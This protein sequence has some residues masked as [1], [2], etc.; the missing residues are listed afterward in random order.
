M[1]EIPLGLRQALEAGECVLFIGAG[2]GGHL[3]RGDE[4]A[5]S[6]AKL[7]EEM[8]K[9]FTLAAG[10]SI[11]LSKVAQI[12]EIRKGRKEL[13]A[14]VTKRLSGFRPDEVFCWIS[15]VRWKAIFTTNYDDALHAA[16]ANTPACPQNPVFSDSASNLAAFDPRFQVP[17]YYLHGR[18]WGHDG[19]PQLIITE[20]DYAQ[21]RKRREMLFELLKLEF[22]KSPFLYVGYANED[23]NW[24]MLLEELRSEFY[25]S[26]LPP[27]YRVAIGTDQVDKEILASKNIQTLDCSF[28]EFQTAAAIALEGSSVPADALKRIQSSVPP[29]LLPAFD[30]NPAAVAR[31]LNSWEFVNR[32]PF[33]EKPNTR[34]FFRGDRANWGLI[35][36][37]VQFERDIEE[38]AY[39]YLLDYATSSASGPGISLVLAPAGYGTTTF[40]RT[41]A[42]RLVRDRVGPVLM[43]R[44][45][46]AFNPGDIEFASTLFEATPFFVID[47][48]ADNHGAVFEAIHRL[49]ETK[50]PAFFL[51]GERLNEWRSA[52]RGRRSGREFSIEPLS[53]AEIDRLLETLEKNNELNALANLSGDLRVVAI[54][55]SYQQEL[56]VTLREATEGRAFDAILEDE[57]R[58]IPDE[59]SRRAYLAVCAF[60][61]HGALIRDNLLAALCGV[62]ILELYPALEN[63]TNGVV[64]FEKLDPARDH[65]A[66][67]ARHRK[68][69]AVVWERC[70]EPGEREQIILGA[71]DKMNLNFQED[72]KAF[73]DFVRSDRLVDSIR[74]LEDRIKFFESACQKDPENPYVRQHYAR[75]L[76]RHGQ[77]NLAL[78]EIDTALRGPGDRIRA[79]HHTKGVILSQMAIQADSRE[80]GRRRLVQAE[81]E[82]R[83][84]L[85]AYP[86]DEYAFQGL[87]G[88]YLDWAESADNNAEST[89]YLA[90][91]E[92]IISEG[93]KTVRNREG[94]WILSSR[95]EDYLGNAP[96]RMDALR[97]A[98]A[99]SRSSVP[100]YL[101]GRALR[102]TGDPKRAI[103]VLQP[104]F[105]Q[106]PD[107]FRVAVEYACAM[108][109]DGCS[110]AQCIAV[111][112]LST[113]YGYSDPRFVATLGGMSF[114]NSDF[115]F[116]ES[117]FD[118]AYKRE[119]PVD[120]ATRIHYRPRNF[121]NKNVPLIWRGRVSSVKAG[122]AFIDV[123]GFPSFFCPGSKFGGLLMRRGVEV[124]FEPT[125]TARGATAHNIKPAR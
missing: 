95:V 29:E 121:E 97:K 44:A 3:S 101:L 124:D 12:V 18:I 61:Q 72:V 80:L 94:L 30:K 84:C 112:K 64:H 108:E 100:G 76:A 19:R 7:A 39:D 21:F 9:H 22:A 109:D 114:M 99:E 123:P 117:V 57:F 54:K 43:L 119:F 13:D 2:I 11:N 75:M 89:D 10:G 40:L 4:T 78:S 50:R 90:K 118:E 8:D 103:E 113:L 23:P 83:N 73:E 67:R 79:L 70:A 110:Y 37:N 15:K 102:R 65:Y 20:N 107:E 56:L 35:A 49:R 28:S 5:P 41:I 106:Q 63:S 46:A 115:S 33:N 71:L 60:Y 93:L 36:N 104:L 52:R 82:F 98:A 38:H 91:S 14:F 66:A 87:A 62:D 55:K 81:D 125:F 25:P 96:E 42:A 92:A 17:V 120:E 16:F 122:Y 48:A 45:S 32:A 88:L 31:L 59:L 6:G 53:D 68:I 77:H 51:L 24:K 105:E 47:S 58:S 85:R 1:V 86:R 26:E 74:K 116:A 27:S 34:D 111:L 69:A